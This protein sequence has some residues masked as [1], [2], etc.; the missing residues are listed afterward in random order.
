MTAIGGKS[1]GEEERPGRRDEM[2]VSKSTYDKLIE[3]CEGVIG[4]RRSGD[5]GEGISNLQ[6]E[7]RFAVAAAHHEKENRKRNR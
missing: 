6:E 5:D 3:V 1:S 7:A 4:Y 2:I